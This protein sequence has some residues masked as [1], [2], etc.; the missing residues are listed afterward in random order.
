MKL[1][2]PLSNPIAN[3]FIFIFLFFNFGSKYKK[4]NNICWFPKNNS[5]LSKIL[6]LPELENSFTK[7]IPSPENLVKIFER[8]NLNL[9]SILWTSI[10][11]VSYDF[12]NS[13]YPEDVKMTNLDI[14]LSYIKKY[15]YIKIYR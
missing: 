10:N 15:M 6:F 12:F 11:S 13:K 8:N 1:F 4:L 14:D 7:W 5:W 3:T 9:F 2:F